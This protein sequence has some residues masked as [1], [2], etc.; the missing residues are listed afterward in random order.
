M[1]Y[2]DLTKQNKPK[3]YKLCFQCHQLIAINLKGD[4]S[5]DKYFG[6]ETLFS[7]CERIHIVPL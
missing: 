3:Q 2:K 7:L 5:E 4:I 1:F 6:V